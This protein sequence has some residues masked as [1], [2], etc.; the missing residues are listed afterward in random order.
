MASATSRVL[1]LISLVNFGLGQLVFNPVN[2]FQ[3]ISGEALSF[4]LNLDS[5]F[6]N[7]GFGKAP[8]DA[9]FDGS[10]SM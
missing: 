1:L 8:K 5:L 10:G 2:N 4:P 3:A 9:N 7:R 6:N